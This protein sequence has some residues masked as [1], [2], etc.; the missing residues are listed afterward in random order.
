MFP[1][2]TDVMLPRIFTDRVLILSR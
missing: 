2:Y 1:E